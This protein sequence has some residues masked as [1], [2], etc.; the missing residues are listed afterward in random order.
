MAL[1]WEEQ[2]KLGVSV[3]YEHGHGHFTDLSLRLLGRWQSPPC[4][5]LAGV[6]IRRV[7]KPSSRTCANVNSECRKCPSSPL[8]PS[9]HL[10][11]EDCSPIEIAT[12]ISHP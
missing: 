3:C 12:E 4:P 7:A 2:R 6:R 9:G 5:A 8:S 11:L 1:E 10:Q